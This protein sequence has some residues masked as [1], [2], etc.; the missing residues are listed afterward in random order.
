MSGIMSG[1][2]EKVIKILEWG[3]CAVQS[4]CSRLYKNL[5]KFLHTYKILATSSYCHRSRIIFYLFFYIDLNL[6]TKIHSQNIDCT[7]K[8]LLD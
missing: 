2:P 4:Y 8:V 7:F 3:I 6:S 5:A 1:N